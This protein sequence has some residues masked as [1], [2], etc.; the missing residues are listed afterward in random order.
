MLQDT[1]CAAATPPGEGGVSVIRISGD[2][3]LSALQKIFTPNGADTENIFQPKPRYMHLGFVKNS[4]EEILDQVLAVY[5]PAPNS[6]TG[7]DVVEIQCHGGYVVTQE[8]IKSLLNVGIVM[9][10][11]GEFTQRAFVNGRMNLTQAEAVID[12]IQAKSAEALKISEKQLEG[13]LGQA[14]LAEND[15]LLDILAQIEVAVDYPEE[16]LDI[17]ENLGLT[18]K[19]NSAINAIDQLI[20]TADDGKIYRE[21]LLTAIVGPANAG[22]S[23]LLNA[24]LQEERAIVTDIAGTTRDTIEEYYNIKGVPVRLVDTAGI[25][26]TSD[27][28]EAVGVERSRQ[29]LAEADLVLLV[30]DAT[31]DLD[32]K[33]R[34]II[35]ES[36]NQ[37]FVFLLNKTDLLADD[38]EIQSKL[39][40]LNNEFTNIDVLPLAA[41][42]NLGVEAVKELIYQKAV[43]GRISA[44]SMVGLVNDRQ[45]S[46]LMRAKNHLKEAVS[47]YEMGI[48]GSM[49]SID[50]QGAWEALAEITGGVVSDDII[51]R[52]FSRFCLGK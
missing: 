24:L 48:E 10:E 6:Y 46:A 13:K 41:K 50:I 35:T 39:S 21:G 7:E 3:A 26:E 14:V 2:E 23:T 34:Q 29:K 33:W 45:K 18:E 17:W 20:K 27:V 16:E 30:W 32:N 43:S 42:D 19:L 8:I 38:S 22:K 44:E 9:A 4:Q 11:P 52:V 15:K 28:V 31:C 40:E 49:I 51:T 1:I 47:A 5:M 12:V 36:T 37:E 25:R